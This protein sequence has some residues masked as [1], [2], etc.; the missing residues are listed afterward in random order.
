MAFD[1]LL[2]VQSPVFILKDV[3]LLHRVKEALGEE[4]AA[5]LCQK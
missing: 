2:P 3:M 5:G 1:V 4:R